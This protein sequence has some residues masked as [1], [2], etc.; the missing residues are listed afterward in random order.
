MKRCKI[1]KDEAWDGEHYVDWT[2]DVV[3]EALR[4]YNKLNDYPGKDNPF[5]RHVLYTTDWKR[6]L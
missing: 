5:G 6:Y 3:D 4:N 2:P 1:G